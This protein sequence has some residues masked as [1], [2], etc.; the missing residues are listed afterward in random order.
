MIQH[1]AEFIQ[2][3]AHLSVPFYLWCC[4]YLVPSVRAAEELTKSSW[5][6]LDI[7][8]KVAGN[9]AYR[10]FHLDIYETM[11]LRRATKPTGSAVGNNTSTPLFLPGTN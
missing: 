1:D 4:F 3:I 9:V 10:H 6:D 2:E 8:S 5:A 11:R 7:A